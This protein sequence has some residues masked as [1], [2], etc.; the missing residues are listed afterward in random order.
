MTPMLPGLLPLVG[1]IAVIVLANWAISTFGVVPVGF[2]LAAPAGVYFAGL[3]FTL[4]DLVQEQL[5]RAWTVVAIVAGAAVSAVISPQF[6]L[7]SGLAFLLSELADFVVYT[8]L[9]HRNWLAAVALSNTVG[10]VADSALFLGLAFGSLEFLAGQI[11]GKL[12]M[13]VLAV[14]LLW[15]WR[16]GMAAAPDASIS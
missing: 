13:T 14:A 16:R 11:V 12:W 5:G 7:A 10:L 2:G 9:R 8:P 3:A 4:R 1:Y 15:A 6:A